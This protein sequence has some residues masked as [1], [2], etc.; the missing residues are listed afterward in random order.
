MLA[1]RMSTERA[2]ALHALEQY[3]QRVRDEALRLERETPLTLKQAMQ[4]ALRI[5]L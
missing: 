5:R 3:P 4:R 2:L 1:V